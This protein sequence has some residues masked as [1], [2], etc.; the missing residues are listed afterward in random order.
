MKNLPVGRQN[1]EEI[2]NENLLYVDKTKQIYEL[3]EKGKLYFFSRPRRFGKSLLIS[4]FR[5]LFSG[6]KQL[7]QDL[8]IGKSTNYSFKKYPVLQF[9]F[10]KYDVNS[11]SLNYFLIADLKTYYSDFK[12]EITRD[13][14]SELLEVLVTTLSKQDK[15]VV[16]L[17]DEY[18]KP[19]VDYLTNIEK[20]KENRNIL[21][22]FFSPLKDLEAQGHLRFLF[23]TGVSKFSKISLFSDLNNL[24]DLTISILSNDLLGITYKELISN[25]Q[26][27]ISDT[28]KQYETTNQILLEQIKNWYNGYSYDGITKLCN[29]FSLLNF[30]LNKKFGNYWFATATPTFLVEQIKNKKINPKDLERVLVED[31]FFDKF[32][33]EDFDMKGLLFQT[34]YL[35][36]KTVEF[37]RFRTQY[38]LSYPNLEVKKAMMH[39]LVEVFTY[40]S[41]STVSEALFVM[42]NG[43]EEG[44]IS[45]FI[46]GLKSILAD[47]SYHW[48][49]KGKDNVQV[50]KMW[51]GYFHTIVYLVTAYMD[52][53]IKAE[54]T[55]HKGR[56]DLL[57][58][59]DEFLYIMEFKLADSSESTLTQIK[60]KQYALPFQHTNKKVFLVGINFSEQER[61]VEGFEIVV[62]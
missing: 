51:E 38:T 59:T 23:V 17:I 28:A 13:T 33:L 45:S 39:N 41:T 1:F 62:L 11:K 58:S 35:T 46:E 47:I 49:P 6:K 2:I 7:F 60:N 34:G 30:F 57:V 42:Q 9:N 19:I 61:N 10:A 56:L 36:I 43:L 16:I 50:F 4:T 8:Y 24:I 52:L 44:N 5:H 18:D 3:I 12:I 27:Y 55:Q 48:Q 22:A 14:P 21:K 29:P 37:K 15:P 20:A 40:K 54:L 32:S 25:F 31:A 26:E 53:D